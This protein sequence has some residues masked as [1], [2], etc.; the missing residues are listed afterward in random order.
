MFDVLGPSWVQAD[1][2][3]LFANGQPIREAKISGNK[4]SG[5]KWTGTWKLPAFRHDVHLVAVASGP[6]VRELYWPIARPYQATSTKVE[7]RVLGI[8]GA[9]WLD[10]DADRKKASAHDYARRLVDAVWPSVPKV[11]AS[12]ADYDE[13]IAAQAAALLRTKGVAINDEPIRAAAR[14]AGSHVDRAFQAYFEAW[15]QSQ[16]AR[17]QEDK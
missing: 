16:V 4:K 12:L 7:R 13:A 10:A 3:E 1:K 11:I 15:R 5:V 8:S 14:K 9:V 6:P 2:V 17:N